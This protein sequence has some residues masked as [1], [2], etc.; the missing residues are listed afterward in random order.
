MKKLLISALFALF[1]TGSAAL[2]GT[3]DYETEMNTEYALEGRIISCTRNET[4]VEDINGHVWEC[5]DKIPQHTKV[6]L[7]M[8]NRG[9]LDCRDDIIV[10]L[11]PT[12]LR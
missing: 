1:V 7:N 4:L 3:L 5:N 6:V 9:T 8:D 10:S 11:V 2:A 12:M